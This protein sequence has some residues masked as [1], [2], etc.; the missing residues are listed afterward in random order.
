MSGIGAAADENVVANDVVFA[1]MLMERAVHGVIDEVVFHQKPFRAFV[2]IQPPAAV[3]IRLDIVNDVVADASSCLRTERVNAAHVG[4]RALPD[5]MN[6]VEFNFISKRHA[7][8]T[9]MPADRY[10]GVV[11]VGNFAMR[12]RVIFRI[13]S[14]PNANGGRMKTPCFGNQAVVDNVVLADAVV[15]SPR[16][17]A[18]YF[19]AACAQVC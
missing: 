19:D 16:G 13:V 11:Q 15:L 9:P 2:W 14:N 17:A 8:V 1:V 4:Q 5:V 12:N 6:P 7:G 10:A 18:A 3:G